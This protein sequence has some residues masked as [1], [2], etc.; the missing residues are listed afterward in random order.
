MS[1]VS[2]DLHALQLFFFIYVTA[3]AQLQIYLHGNYNYQNHVIQSSNM[4]KP[5]LIS[6]VTNLNTII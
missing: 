2:G 5:D 3:G 4:T 1:L 6:R